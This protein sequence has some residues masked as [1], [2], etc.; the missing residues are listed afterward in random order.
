MCNRLENGK[1]QIMNKSLRQ[2]NRDNNG[3]TI[4]ETLV[5]IAI[6]MISIAGPLA[7][8]SKSLTA[9]LYAKDQM[10]ASYLAQ[11][12]VETIRNRKDNNISTPP[13]KWLKEI[14]GPGVG[15]NKC[16]RT[17]GGSTKKCSV[18]NVNDEDE[19][20]DIF[21]RYYYIK[22]I[23]ADQEVQVTVVVTWKHGTVNN[24][25]SIT[26]ELTNITL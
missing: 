26:T 18:N 10:I 9:A 19:V 13:N 8:A 1:L 22:E 25:T 20:I 6:L 21:T 4:I 7:V 23:I 12:G 15:G 24:E 5:A 11:E 3:F 14:T 16:E 17:G 2:N